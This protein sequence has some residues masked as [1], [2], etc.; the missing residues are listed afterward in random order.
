MSI[1]NVVISG[2]IGHVDSRSTQTGTVI[3]EFS[4]AVNE[5]MQDKQTGEWKDRA[6]WIECVIFGR[7]AESLSRFLEK[8]MKVSVAGKLRQSSWEKD[9]QKR[10]KVQVVAD[11]IELPPRS[12]SPVTANYAPSQPTPDVQQGFASMGVPAGNVYAMDDLPF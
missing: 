12:Q 3:L 4:V 10:S 1:N 9:G 6:N 7:R 2:N 11:E 5:R 8:G